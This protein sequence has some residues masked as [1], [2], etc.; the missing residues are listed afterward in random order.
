[1]QRAPLSLGR[2]AGCAEKACRSTTFLCVSR[3][4]LNIILWF[5]VVVVDHPPV[6]SL[7]GA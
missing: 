4:L 6:F 5:C 3:F 7:S 2:S 1:M